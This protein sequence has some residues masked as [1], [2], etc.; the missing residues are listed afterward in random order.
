MSSVKRLFAES[1]SYF[2]GNL[3]VILAGFISFPIMTRI[4]SPKDYGVFSLAIISISLGVSLAKCG[5]QHSA[6]RFYSEFNEN[7]HSLDRMSSYYITPIFGVAVVNLM[8]IGINAVILA[9]LRRHLDG[10]LLKLIPLIAIIIFIKSLNNLIE[11]FLRAERR[12]V[13]F[14]VITVLNKYGSLFLSLFIVFFIEHSLSGFFTGMAI[15]EGAI[16]FI[17]LFSYR[18]KLDIKKI[19]FPFLKE[20]LSFG[21]PLIWMELANL[22]LSFGD[23]Y[24][25]EY[26]M[27]SSAVGVYPPRA[28]MTSSPAASRTARAPC[29][30]DRARMRARRAS[31]T[32]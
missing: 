22:L 19:S 2:V 9:T 29:C 13:F 17:L 12:G 21:F 25:I 5:L 11:V 31:L 28:Y 3:F 6:L 15:S 16:L 4:F 1:S 7:N 10:L 24:L 23:R 27:G 8:L 20:S 18:D 30:S 26:Y 14:N 32:M